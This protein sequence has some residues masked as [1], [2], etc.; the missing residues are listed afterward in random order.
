MTF[1]GEVAVGASMLLVAA[2]VY[3]ILMNLVSMWM[4][5]P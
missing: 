1:T 2:F 4:D 3:V 5:M